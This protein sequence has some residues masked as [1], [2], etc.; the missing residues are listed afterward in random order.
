MAILI[1][2]GAGY[3]GSHACVELMEAGYDIVVIDNFSNSHP[4]SMRR[5]FELE[6]R[7]FPVYR[8]DL[9]D[10]L[11]V[12][13]IFQEH[14]I[15]A[16]MHFAGLKAVGE[17][18]SLPLWYYHNNMAGTLN[19]CEAMRMHG[20]KRLV[21]SSSA[22]V[23]GEPQQLPIPE[24]ANTNATNPYGRTKWMIEQMLQDLYESDPSWSISILRY[25]N[26]IGAH[27]SGRIGEDPNGVPNNLVPYI[28][29]VAVGKL[30]VLKIYGNDYA[31][32]DG[33]GIR[34]YIHVVDLAQG[35]VRALERVMKTTGIDV[36][37]LGTGTG[38]SVLEVVAAFS[39]AS[40]KHIPYTFT[41]RRA[42][43]VAICYADVT[44]AR[45]VLGWEAQRNLMQMC[46]D[47]WR[48]QCQNPQGYA[49]TLRNYNEVC[50]A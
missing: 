37:N 24:T 34:D 41:E 50:Q 3:I 14:E 7:T 1:T 45:D 15:E 28:A 36:F 20:V 40:G 35:H 29:Q 26:P 5:V 21:F 19:L 46:E 23:Y 2:G 16:V 13:R 22:T 44:K 38:Y 30:E 49:E 18:V 31:T 6:G 12:S 27:A 42:G 39:E 25:F 4:E 9:S 11:G 32:H 10:R 48:W 47:T 17:S 8:V 43:D 33:T